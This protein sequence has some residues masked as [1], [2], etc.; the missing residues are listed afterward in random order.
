MPVSDIF[1]DTYYI[2]SVQFC[3][4]IESISPS[5]SPI[6]AHKSS[7]QGKAYRAMQVHKSVEERDLPQQSEHQRQ[8]FC[9]PDTCRAERRHQEKP[10]M[11]DEELLKPGP[12]YEDYLQLA[13]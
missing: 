7:Q 12:R 3:G 6:A 10:G 2:G 13:P 4:Q 8:R 9:P 5:S 1:G 11:A